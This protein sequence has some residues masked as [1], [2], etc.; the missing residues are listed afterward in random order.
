MLRSGRKFL[1]RPCSLG[2]LFR[3]R[4][5]IHA[6]VRSR[7]VRVLGTVSAA[8]AAIAIAACQSATQVSVELRTDLPCARVR[9][10]AITVGGT[11]LE[12]KAPTA[13]STF[14]DE[15]GKLGVLVV[16]PSAGSSDEFGVR[17]IL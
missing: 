11:D 5:T 6:V 17:A 2:E 7:S 14:C 8:I 15:A 16:V 9:E 12:S 3:A 1:P 13:T 4:G 10:T